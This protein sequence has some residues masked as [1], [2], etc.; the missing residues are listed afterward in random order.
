M[1]DQIKVHELAIRDL[2]EYRHRFIEAAREEE[3]GGKSGASLVDHLSWFVNA[4]T[5]YL[6]GNL[7]MDLAV[8]HASALALTSKK[9]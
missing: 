6:S 8:N 9:E 3:A 5:K 7:R 2:R 1:E 4:A